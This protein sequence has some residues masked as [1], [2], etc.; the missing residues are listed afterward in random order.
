M[1]LKG[2]RTPKRGQEPLPLRV[3]T[4]IR[5][6]QRPS[7]GGVAHQVESPPFCRA[8]M[9]SLARRGPDLAPAPGDEVMEVRRLDLGSEECGLL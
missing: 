9:E 8:L 3:S 2:P 5:K 6:P 1:F 7:P 4:P